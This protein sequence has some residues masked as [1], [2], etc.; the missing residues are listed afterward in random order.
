MKK[1]IFKTLLIITTVIILLTVGI[2]ITLLWREQR[3]EN[4][5]EE[6][7][8]L[9]FGRLP[10]TIE[11]NLSNNVSLEFNIINGEPKVKNTV[12]K[13][14]RDSKFYPS[15]ILSES[16]SSNLG[17]EP[18]S[19]DNDIYTYKHP[20]TGESLE[21]NDKAK[22]ITLYLATE[23]ASQENS[24]NKEEGEKVAKDKLEEIKLWPYKNDEYTTAYKYYVTS[25]YNYYETASEEDAD[26][27]SVVY[28]AK[29]NDISLISGRLNTGEIEALIDTS[30][31]ISK[32]TYAHR[33]ISKEDTATYPVKSIDSV[34]NLI[35]GGYGE[36]IIPFDGI[37][38]SSINITKSA[39]AYRIEFIDQE[40]LQPVYVLEGLDTNAQLVTIIVPAIEDQYLE[41]S[42]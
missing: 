7:F 4:T 5:P 33:P 30:Y 10:S 3:G 29:I 24:F 23:A 38:P 18:E 26:L 21:Y 31:R 2:V 37:N 36:L 14:N 19:D 16:I 28:S 12:Y 42:K 25:G 41:T 40:Y 34:I 39:S 20:E 11:D 35:K 6:K 27:V 9:A 32:I 13:V 8:N 1:R 15:K 22:V 17:L